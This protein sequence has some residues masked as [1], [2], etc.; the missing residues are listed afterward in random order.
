MASRAT[1]GLW[2]EF[3]TQLFPG[4]AEQDPAFQKDIQRIGRTGLLVIGSMQIG[5]SLFM[6]LARFVIAPDRSTLAFRAK[7]AALIVAFGIVA[8]ICAHSNRLRAWWRVI[9]IASGLILSVILVWASLLMV[10]A[11]AM[12]GDFIPG[13]ITLIMLVAVTVLPLLPIQTLA[14]GLSIG[15]IYI[16]STYAATSL[17]NVGHGPEQT[18]LLFIFMLTLLCTAL[19]MV[20]YRQRRAKFDLQQQ[21]MR[22]L[23]AENASSFTKLAAAL[24]HELNNP[25]GALLSGVDTLLL[26]ASRQAT[27]APED[28]S[29]LVLVQ[30]DVRKSIQQSAKRLKAII[31]RIQR[32]TNLDKAEVQNSSVNE[33]LADVAAIIESQLPEGAK[34]NLDLQPV[35]PIVCRPQQ[36]SAV[37]ANLL[38]NAV[39]A[40]NGAGGEIRIATRQRKDGIEVEICDTGRGIDEEQLNEIFEPGFKTSGT[41]VRASNWSMFTARH[42]VREHG[43]DIEVASGKGRGTTVRVRFPLSATPVT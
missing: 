20:V 18:Y 40:L 22:I 14:L 10:A 5:I 16:G 13:Q 7:Q 34:L 42:I 11:G 21:Q 35:Q 25:I 24:S 29:R 3:R 6:L 38:G 41:R 8:I 37:F 2:R 31:G 23:L 30:A 17:L 4:S 19:T 43:G 36:I 28:Q 26:L 1:P 15:A 12:P 39:R 9:G 32:F 33:L 27:C